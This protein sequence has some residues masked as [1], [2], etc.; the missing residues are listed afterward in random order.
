MGLVC[1]LRAVLTALLTFAL[2]GTIGCTSEP[3]A[4]TNP[5]TQNISEANAQ[6]DALA[7]SVVSTF[8]KLSPVA[9]T[10]LGDHR[11]DDRL[12]EISPAARAQARAKYETWLTALGD[13]DTS[14]LTRDNQIDAAL[15]AQ[16]LRGSLWKQD[17]LREWQW[18]PLIYTSLSG[19]A[20]YSLMARD[21]APLDER[22]MNAAARLEQMP[23]FLEQ[24]RA[25]LVPADVPPV[26]AETAVKQNRGT[27]SII[28]ALIKPNLDA[29]EA[30][31]RARL[32]T[33]IATAT[34][35]VEAHQ[36]WL[37]DTLT[38]AAAGEFRVGAEKFD[39]KLGFTL[40]T[41]LS[42]QEI[43]ARAEREFADV[44]A[45]MYAT[46]RELV[47]PSAPAQPTPEQQQAI[48][49]AGLELAYARVPQRDEIVAVARESLKTAT[50]FVRAKDI[51]E[52]PDDPV[53]I[54]LMPEFQ[55]G[56]AVAYCDAPGPLDRGQETFYAV[57]PLPED[58]TDKQVDS[59]L[60]EYNLLSIED[61]TIHEAM[62]GHFLQLALA[63]RHPSL[64]RAMLASGPFIEG[65]A[66]YAER[67]MIDEGYLN[68]DPL[69]RLVNLKWYLRV[70]ANAIIDQAIH[71]DGMDRD[72][73]MELMTRGAFQE[74]REAAGKWVR[75]QLSSTQLSTYFVGY[76][77][78][79][80][81]RR[82]IQ[83]AWGDGFS[84]RRYHDAV[85]SHGSPP[86]QYARAQLLAL[87][88]Q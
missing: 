58:W 61:L 22:L 87:P 54:I 1:C 42:R 41:P 43:R 6:F 77:E 48:I 27:L 69:M 88:I 62:P 26:H 2:L 52:V 66:V 72:E 39:V 73:A 74:E 84:L 31:D 11:F 9:A 71:V 30:A 10:G 49:Q 68:G 86:V 36:T 16:E 85:L 8:P 75:A 67:V 56:V 21:F 32:E 18:N 83:K 79:A 29:L 12:D 47:D 40:Y 20:V 23:R 59:F 33:A 65:W 82:E 17:V 64:L 3:V 34:D 57:A 15:L 76:Q 51:V 38:P 28:D 60:R 24:V 53:K 19:G 14:Q 7:R 46:A 78:H 81:L 55:R 37:E 5:D 50:E 80:D 63:N 13:I 35:A 70:I 44:R 45:Q 25:T 4:T